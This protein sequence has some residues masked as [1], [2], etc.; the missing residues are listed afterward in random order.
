MTAAVK[1]SLANL[2]GFLVMAHNPEGCSLDLWFLMD[3]EKCHWNKSYSLDFQPENLLA[4]PLEIL[5]DG[6]IVLS[7]SG[8]LRLY[9]PITKS[10]T[11]FGMRDSTYVA[12]YTGN[13]V[14][15]PIHNK[16]RSFCIKLV[17]ILY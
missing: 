5:N 7:V 16:C 15:P 6:K 4:Q 10:Y 2:D 9:N 14:L 13:M 17:Q 11:D 1:L 12:T 8:S 3:V